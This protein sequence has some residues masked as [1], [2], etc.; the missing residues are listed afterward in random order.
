MHSTKS[1]VCHITL[2]LVVGS[3]LISVP[4]NLAATERI[5]IVVHLFSYADGTQGLSKPTA[6]QA[7]THLNA[8]FSSIFNEREFIIT[9]FT[10]TADDFW[11]E[12]INESNLNDLFEGYN[13][14]DTKAIN[15]YFVPDL[16]SANGLAT[17]PNSRLTLLTPHPTYI[18]QGIV[19][20]NDAALS[21]TLPHEFGHFFGLFHTY[22]ERTNN[23]NGRDDPTT[24]ADD[25]E[26]GDLMASTP[27]EPQP[28]VTR[29]N[30]SDCAYTDGAYHSDGHNYMSYGPDECR[31]SFTQEQKS[32]M[33]DELTTGD[34]QYLTGHLWVQVMNQIDDANAGGTFYIENQTVP[35][36]NYFDF[37][38]NST[39]ITTSEAILQT[40]YRHHDWNNEDTEFKLTLSDFSAT[41]SS[42][43]QTANFIGRENVHI[44]SDIPVSLHIQDPWLSQNTTDYTTIQNGTH[45]GIFLNQGDPGNPNSDAPYYRLRAPATAQAD[46][47]DWYFQQWDGTD[48]TFQHPDR[49]TSSVVFRHADARAEAMY[50]GQFRSN[51]PLATAYSNGRKVMVRTHGSIHYSL[52]LRPLYLN[53]YFP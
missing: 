49:R 50:K 36:G 46:E 32:F 2:L 4:S 12:G 37:P 6:R 28:Q 24:S 26:R 16:A 53:T 40:N 11:A 43:T 52:N 15:L 20:E 38:Q 41:A 23:G 18:G 27:E 34:R 44:Q 8:V 21:S 51:T 9:N 42:P 25:T 10:E 30:W 3:T 13:S 14:L 47:T 31:E 17:I 45:Q 48:V 7:M 29:Y 35:S 19:V 33:R 1:L 39:D 22:E 5:G